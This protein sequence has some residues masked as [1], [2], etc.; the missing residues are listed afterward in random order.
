MAQDAE[1]YADGRP[2]LPEYAE[3]LAYYQAMYG[4]FLASGAQRLSKR[5]SDPAWRQRVHATYGLIARGAES[6]PYA[7]RLLRDAN[8]DAREDAATIL[9]EVGPAPRAVDALLEALA[10]ERDPVTL[11]AIVHG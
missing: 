3:S 8:P 5:D 10:A 9:L 2:H 11:T 7:L 1:R 4:A 6:I